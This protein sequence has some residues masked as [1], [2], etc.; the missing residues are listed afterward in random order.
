[1]ILILIVLII[2]YRILWK[3]YGERCNLSVG[4]YYYCCYVVVRGGKVGRERVGILVY[5]FGFLV[6]LVIYFGVLKEVILFVN[7]I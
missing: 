4:R 7:L 1:M 3:V 2:V 5:G 6:L